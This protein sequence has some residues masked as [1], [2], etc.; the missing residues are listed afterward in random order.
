VREVNDVTIYNQRPYY[1]VDPGCR[2]T[3]FLWREFLWWNFCGRIQ[4]HVLCKLRC[5]VHLRVVWLITSI[6]NMKTNIYK[7]LLCPLSPLSPLAVI[8]CHYVRRKRIDG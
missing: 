1:P 4:R 3:G 6:T 2:T 8:I 5:H 7:H